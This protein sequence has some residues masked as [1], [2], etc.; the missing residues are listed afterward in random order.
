MNGRTVDPG[1]AI[2]ADSIP[3]AEV[4]RHDVAGLMAAARKTTGLTDF[5]TDT[6]FLEGLQ[7]LVEAANL[8]TEFPVAAGHVRDRINNYL[9]MRL[10][11]MEDER[12]HPEI[13][14]VRIDRPIIIIGLPRSG[15][16]VTFD[17]LAQDPRFRYPRDWEWF[18]PWPATEAATIETDP[19]IA[20]LQPLFEQAL[21]LDPSLAA[22]HRFDC[23][24]PGECNTGM[25]YH[26]AGTNY[27]AELSVPLHAQWV[28]DVLPE[29][30]YRDH[31]R[32][33]RQMSWKGPKG[34]WILKSPHHLFDLEGL[35]RTYPD[36]RL[37]WTH[38]DPIKTFSSL[39]SL[40]NGVRPASGLPHDPAGVG[41]MT[42]KI[43]SKAILNAVSVRANHPEIEAKILD[44][45]QSRIAA[46]PIGAVRAIYEHAG[47][48]PSPDFD[49]RTASFIGGDTKAQRL[50]QHKHRPGDFGIDAAA[51][52]RELAPYYD[53]F[54]ALAG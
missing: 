10:H 46:D 41:S 44:L 34:R 26:F 9:C 53:R 37:I 39:A 33:L 36:A 31:K 42:T 17:L 43:W 24:A 12:R 30:L 27:W 19:R 20:L 47:E 29:G 15:T 38:R 18:I 54:G 21:L 16:T 25:M 28:L 22:V 11:L 45:P 1:T 2:V 52:K 8:M 5:G 49:A 4:V 51:V 48:T 14:D 13:L 6:S 35:V 40:V 50:G 7:V 32:L 3:P 23:R